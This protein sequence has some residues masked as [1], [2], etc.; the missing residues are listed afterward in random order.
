[1]SIFNKIKR[2]EDQKKKDDEQIKWHEEV[3]RR[4]RE[5]IKTAELRFNTYCIG[6]GRAGIHFLD[7][8]YSLDTITRVNQIFPL[9]LPSSRYDY[10]MADNIRKREEF[11]FPFGASDRN[12]RFSGV[13]GD[14]HLGQQ[15]AIKDGRNILKKMNDEI[16]MME[17]RVPI[18]AI[19]LIG[20]LAGGTGGGAIPTFAKMIKDNFPEQLLMIIGILPEKE[21]GNT[22]L[23]NASRSFHMIN[24]LK[25]ELKDKYADAIFIF[26]N[27]IVRGKGM[28]QSYDYIN[29]YLA[30]TFNLLFGSS[31]SPDTLDP[32]D[33]MSV[34][35]K[36]GAEGIGLMQ[37]T[38]GQEVED[39]TPDSENEMDEATAQIIRILDKNLSNYPQG[40]V[41]S[42]TFGAYQIRCSQDIFPF[43]VRNT[44]NSNFEKRL[45][46]GIPGK[47]A[48][49]RGGVWPIPQ[50]E[51]VEISTMIL[52]IDP[53]KYEYLNK[54]M[55]MWNIWYAKQDVE[56][57]LNQII[58]LEV[59]I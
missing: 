32:Q 56:N 7:S 34:L 53:E 29:N 5:I 13:G 26:E 41:E 20:S 24:E 25:K 2:K 38:G 39:S 58:S 36:G 45:E 27:M 16:N 19:A 4:E 48:F 40:T 50:S 52:G 54:I 22:Y 15:I 43:N 21:E 17:R 31:Y 8:I 30:K 44:L 6:I 37:Y 59:A 18:K 35:K 3:K 14:Q 1:M 55:E 9:A 11:I 46:A 47:N 33:K 51:D 49:V 28:L 42:G 57:D 10:Q 23:A 12:V